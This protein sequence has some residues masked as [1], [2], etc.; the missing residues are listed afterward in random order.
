LFKPLFYPPCPTK[1]KPNQ[2]KQKT[3][4]EAIYFINLFKEAA[5]GFKM[6]PTARHWGLTPVI[7]VTQ[8]A[9]IRRVVV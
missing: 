5:S 8:E 6:F 4:S 7:L 2:T 1:K 9:E 3:V